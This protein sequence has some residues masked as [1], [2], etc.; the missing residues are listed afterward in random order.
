MR[1]NKLYLKIILAFAGAD[2]I[3]I[4]NPFSSLQAAPCF[5]STHLENQK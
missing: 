2:V 3:N 4:V 5:P 1:L